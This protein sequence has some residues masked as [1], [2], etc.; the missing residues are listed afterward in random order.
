MK[1]KPS[2]K[3]I[4]ELLRF[5]DLSDEWDYKRFKA[6]QEENR[7]S[8]VCPEFLALALYHGFEQRIKSAST[9]AN[10]IIYNDDYK[11]SRK[12]L[13]SNYINVLRDY[14]LLHLK[15]DFDFISKLALNTYY[16]FLD[17]EFIVKDLKG[18]EVEYKLFNFLNKYKGDKESKNVG[19][20]EIVFKTNTDEK[21]SLK[22]DHTINKIIENVCQIINADR[23][24]FMT[25][26]G[27]P[28][29]LGRKALLEM[30]SLICTYLD[31]KSELMPDEGVR[32]PEVRK[33][34][35]A[36]L[37][38]LVTPE[39]FIIDKEYVGSLMKELKGKA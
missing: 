7:I 9:K 13:E 19:I 16:S 11:K 27:R 10:S 31:M 25:S 22:E 4:T 20:K 14:G 38:D 2:S 23:H 29:S 8:K 35:I 33:N 5:F 32:I 39:S 17:L 37:L 18:L 21:F 3:K 15:E 24:F 28:I 1:T 30:C 34:F 6:F 36:D 26:K 12:E